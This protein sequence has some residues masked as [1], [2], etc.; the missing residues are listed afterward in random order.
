[1]AI[2]RAAIR[3]IVTQRTLLFLLHQCDDSSHVSWQTAYALQRS[4]DRAL[5]RSEFHRIEPLARHRDPL[6]RLNAAALFGKLTGHGGVLNLLKLLLSDTDWRVRVNA[7]RSI[8]A[9]GKNSAAPIRGLMP[10]ALSDPDD[11]VAIAL[12][13]A[14]SASPELL[15]TLRRNAGQSFRSALHTVLSERSPQCTAAAAMVYAALEGT[16]SL[17][18]LGRLAVRDTGVAPYALRAIAMINSDSALAIVLASLDSP[19]PANVCA[20]L[21][22]LHARLGDHIGNAL[23]LREI[24]LDRALRA[25]ERHDVSIVA[26]A[27]EMLTDSA[28][29][30]DR[31]APRLRT[32]IRQLDP[33]R[34]L[35]AIQSVAR[36]LNVLG[37]TTAAPASPVPALPAGCFNPSTLPDTIHVTMHT[38]AGIIA[39]ELYTRAAPMT[40]ASFVW[41][42]EKFFTG[43]P[44]HRVVPNFVVQ[45]GDPRGDGWGGPGYVIPSEFSLLEY[46]EGTMGMASSG[47][48][49][50]GSQFF[51][52]HSP[53]PHLDGRYTVFG[54][55]V[56][57]LDVLSRIQRGARILSMTISH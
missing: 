14:V 18:V 41:L 17:P 49:T 57:G 22:G 23:T 53:Q 27:A 47:K 26:T 34:D 2:A 51:F 16:S 39:C 37:D 6:V 25:L 1:M 42:G 36:T 10:K 48:D 9:W 19:R 3:G 46:G 56:S 52:T 24:V 43:R 30:S 38:E 54:R 33:V 21:E 12:L 5:F 35:E 50:E 44:F 55:I 15:D 28:L 11:H 13:E 20:A 29:H 40:V 32:I 4:G 45:G 31:V 7:A 8:V